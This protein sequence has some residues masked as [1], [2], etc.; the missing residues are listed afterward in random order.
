MTK[1]INRVT[2]AIGFIAS[3]IGLAFVA[4]SLAAFL[5]TSASPGAAF[6]LIF[7]IIGT[8]ILFSGLICLVSAKQSKNRPWLGTGIL[9][10]AAVIAVLL[11]FPIIITAI[12]VLLGALNAY[13]TLQE[14]QKR[15]TSKV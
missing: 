4:V 3:I 9:I 14:F 6:F 15:K 1:G 11:H 8:V 13:R 10:V 12:L 2:F 5:V 7:T